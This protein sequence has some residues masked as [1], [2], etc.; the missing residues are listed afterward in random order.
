MIYKSRDAVFVDT[1]VRFIMHHLTTYNFNILAQRLVLGLALSVGPTVQHSSE[2]QFEQKDFLGLETETQILL[3]LFFSQ[4]Q[5]T[6]LKKVYVS[7]QK[8]M[9]LDLTRLF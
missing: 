8:Q 4:I 3:K 1:K 6:N 9:P 2:I 7:E 5:D